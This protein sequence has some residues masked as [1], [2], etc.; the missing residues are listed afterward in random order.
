MTVTTTQS[1][2]WASRLV[3]GV[4]SVKPLARWAKHQARQR[5]INRAEKM[6][7]PWRQ[8]SESLLSRSWKA[9][10]TEVCDPNLVYP[11]Y[12]RRSFHAYETGN[13]SWQAAS[14]VEVAAISV[15]A[16]IWPEA[17]IEGDTCLRRSYHQFLQTQLPSPPQTIVD[18]GC[19]VGMSTFALQDLYPQANITGIDLSPYFLAIALYQSQQRSHSTPQ[20]LHRAAEST[21]LPNASVDLV[22][23]FLVCHELP[24]AATREIF[25]EARRIL[26]PG[27]HIAIMDMNPQSEVMKRIPP[28]ILTLLKSTEPFLDQYFSLDLEQTLKQTGFNTPTVTIN[29]PRHRT[30]IAQ[31]G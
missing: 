9:E 27:G 20:W 2:D 15:H 12:Y 19:G 30:I 26:R 31:C 17:G 13:L 16:K 29:S 4:L 5:M 3:N 21:G 6:G 8:Q 10:W 22:S 7:V 18:L 23:L 11:D 1:G 24:Q 14:E 28:Y 25:Q